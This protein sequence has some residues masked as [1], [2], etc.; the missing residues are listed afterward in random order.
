MGVYEEKM[1]VDGQN[2]IYCAQF[3]EKV[4]KPSKLEHFQNLLFSEVFGRFLQ[5]GCSKPNFD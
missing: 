3:K 5:N 1:E 4:Q 2:F